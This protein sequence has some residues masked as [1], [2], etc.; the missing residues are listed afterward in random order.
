M[1]SESR[2]FT[3]TA[4][5]GIITVWSIFTMYSNAPF[6][7][8]ITKATQGMEVT[9]IEFQKVDETTILLT[10]EFENTSSLDITL[11]SLIFNLYANSEF[12]GNF[13]MRERKILPPGNT[14]VMMVAD[15]QERYIEELPT[16]QSIQWTV[17]GGAV[18]ELPMEEEVTYTIPITAGWVTL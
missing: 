16:G 14:T 4:I 17:N 12:M 3:M 5:A 6:Y 1:K 18:I 10:F 11:N 8:E 9:L 13:G 15:V 7:I 2:K